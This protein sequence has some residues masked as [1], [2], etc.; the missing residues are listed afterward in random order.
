MWPLPCKSLQYAETISGSWIMPPRVL[1]QQGPGFREEGES[2]LGFLERVGF[3]DREGW[4][5]F[6]KMEVWLVG[7][8]DVKVGKFKMFWRVSDYSRA[9]VGK[10]QESGKVRVS[11]DPECPAQIHGW[12]HES[13]DFSLMGN[14]G[15][16]YLWLLV[17]TH[18][19]N[20]C[21]T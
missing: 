3:R 17:F 10:G 6:W 15:W 7:M 20:M 1:R 2:S 8:T 4:V 12:I 19:Y 14:G 5:E 18:Y 11:Q 16:T 13:M 21:C 9:I